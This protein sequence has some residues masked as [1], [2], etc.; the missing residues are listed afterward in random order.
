LAACPFVNLKGSEKLANNVVG[1]VP[2]ID[3]N[4]FASHELRAQIEV[5]P[6]CIDLLDLLKRLPNLKCRPLTTTTSIAY[7]YMCDLLPAKSK[8]LIILRHSE[9]LSDP[10]SSNDICLNLSP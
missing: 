5:S 3:A 2:T 10:K 6:G 8:S 9:K 7:T 1:H 4:Q